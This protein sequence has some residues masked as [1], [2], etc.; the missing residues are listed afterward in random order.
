MRLVRLALAL[1]A[2]LPLSSLVSVQ[3][4]LAQANCRWDLNGEW[5]GQRSGNR[6]MQEMR[7]G[8]F[9][10]W[11]VGSPK[12]GQAEGD[13]MFR[14]SGP[15][16]WTWTFPDGQKSVARLEANGM[17]RV[18]NP[19]GWS[20]TFKRISP[21]T[22]PQCLSPARGSSTSAAASPP[23]A[24]APAAK[25]LAGPAGNR[26]LYGITHADMKELIESEGHTVVSLGTYAGDGGVTNLKAVG[27]MPA[28]L[29]YSVFGRDCDTAAN[30]SCKRLQFMISYENAS[31]TAED[32]VA[33]NSW[34][35]SL[36]TSMADING[37]R[38]VF[39]SWHLPVQD[40]VPM[41]V[42]RSGF[43]GFLTDQAKAWNFIL[44]KRN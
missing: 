13:H 42:I 17:L 29:T 19:D 32:V 16:V 36:N 31:V 41:R 5:V 6:V 40:G 4:A 28:G 35:D 18:T 21:A 38:M 23:M 3:P 15:K 8:G 20:E 25:P 7:P 26:V 27:K 2:L 11:V 12:P 39:F 14:D 30:R 10:V 43:K 34:H 44:G 24:S 33:T 37:K 1:S 22:P 9:M